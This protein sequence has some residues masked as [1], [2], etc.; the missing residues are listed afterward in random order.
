[1]KKKFPEKAAKFFENLHLKF[2][3]GIADFSSLRFLNTAYGRRVHPSTVKRI[4]E[5]FEKTQDVA[6]LWNLEGRPRLLTE[7]DTQRLEAAVLEDR[8]ASCEELKEELELEVSHDTINRELHRIGHKA[9]RA[10]QKPMLSDSNVVKR[11]AFAEDHQDWLDDD[12]SQ[13]IFTDESSFSLAGADGRVLIRRK[14]EEA[15][16]PDTYQQVGHRTQTVA[17]WGLYLLTAVDLWSESKIPLMVK[18]LLTCFVI[19]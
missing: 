17:V 15:F 7:E 16:L 3:F 18:G 12:W 13:V 11:L 1:L 14:P 8:M 10:P 6:N 9:Y 19:A 5:K 4:C 2:S